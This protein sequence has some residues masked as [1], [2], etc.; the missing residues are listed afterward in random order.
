MVGFTNSTK[1]TINFFQKKTDLD[2]RTKIIIV[3]SLLIAT[4]FS[5]N[6]F[7]LLGLLSF[8]FSFLIQIKMKI[9]H[10]I[11][12]IGFITFFSVIAAIIAYYTGVSESMWR[13][14]VIIELR[15]LIS[16]FTML[17]FFSTVQPYE[18][19]ASL[20]R[21]YFPAK[22]VWFLTTVYQIIPLIYKEAS[23]INGI[24]KIRGLTA[25]KIDIKGQYRI[26]KHILKPLVVGSINRG[27]D[28]AEAMVIKGFNGKR[29]KNLIL[30]PKL[31]IYEYFL[32]LLCL[33]VLVL[34]MVFLRR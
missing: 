20:E 25:K 9:R 19:A 29:R 24:R 22:F 15:F 31:Y 30:K 14:F 21:S 27:I 26:I 18:L 11:L 3:L 17:W 23:S 33:V 16:L 13:A 8:S 12:S 1:K 2:P 4:I 34:I 7:V 5:S 28:L 32:I 6:L 10:L